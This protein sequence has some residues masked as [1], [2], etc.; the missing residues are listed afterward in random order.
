MEKNVQLIINIVVDI[1]ED[2][3]E[4]IFELMDELDYTIT[5]EEIKIKNTEL[6]EYNF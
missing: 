2:Q 6:V 5:H 4:N 1:T 3:E